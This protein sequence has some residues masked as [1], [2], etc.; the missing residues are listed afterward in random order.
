MHLQ[1][2]TDSEN[3][4]M[5]VGERWWRKRTFSIQQIGDSNSQESRVGCSPHLLLI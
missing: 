5:L 3:A 4:M 2:E 1:R